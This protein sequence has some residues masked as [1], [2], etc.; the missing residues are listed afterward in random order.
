MIEEQKT[1]AGQ[2]L[3]IAGLVLGIIALIIAFIP[4][5]G[6]AALIPGAIAV[7]LS[8]IGLSQANKGNGAKGLIIAAL[9]VSI[10]GTSVAAVWGIFFATVAKEGHRWKDQIENMSD[11]FKIEN[12]DSM[13]DLGKELEGALKD[14]EDSDTAVFEWGEEISDQDF[15]R[16]LNQYDSLVNE[17][18]KL[19]KKAKKGDISSMSAYSKISVKAVSLATK[20]AKVAPKLTEE[21]RQ[22]FEE[23]QK[24]YDDALEEVE[25]E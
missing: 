24:K 17:Y 16:L 6:L 23:V 7:V 11:D 12:D 19:A 10:V 4:C 25:K 18:I 21:Q 8:A 1:T 5:V 13:E 15:D 22:R 2:G 20:L 14:L 9:V 3:G